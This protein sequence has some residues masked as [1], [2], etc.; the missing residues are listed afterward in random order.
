MTNEL[1]YCFS[2]NFDMKSF[3]IHKERHEDKPVWDKYKPII[4]KDRFLDKWVIEC[5][6]CGME[7]IFDENKQLSIDLWNDIYR[8]DEP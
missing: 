6:N 1:K 3:K 5:Q 2:C 7:V 8:K 4:Y